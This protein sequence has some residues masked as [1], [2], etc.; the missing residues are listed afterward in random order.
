MCGSKKEKYGL[1]LEKVL[2][3]YD[4]GDIKNKKV[5]RKGIKL[6]KKIMKNKKNIDIVASWGG[7]QS[8][9]L[10]DYIL[11]EFDNKGYYG[12]NK[13]AFKKTYKKL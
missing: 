5:I 9:H 6:T 12:I 2:N 3:T 4:V 1:P 7:K 11:L 13:E 8:L 10:G